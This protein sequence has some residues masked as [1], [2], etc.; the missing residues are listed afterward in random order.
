M[1]ELELA[2]FFLFPDFEENTWLEEIQ[3][4]NGKFYPF[5]E[6]MSEFPV[7]SLLSRQNYHI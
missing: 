4:I 3:M 2:G 7:W 1:A 5:G 6:T